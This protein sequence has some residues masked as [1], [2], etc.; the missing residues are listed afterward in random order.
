MRRILS[1][2]AAAAL[3]ATMLIAG[4]VAAAGPVGGC[5]SGGSW[6]LVFPIHQPQ[7]AD[8]NGDGWLCRA[9]FWVGP[10]LLA[11]DNVI[12]ED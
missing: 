6:R 2:A 1:L 12:R 8:H 9:D 11:I 4:T 3:T 10:G 7:A 5:P